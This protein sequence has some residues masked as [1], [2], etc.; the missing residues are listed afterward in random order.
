MLHQHTGW[1]V[2]ISEWLLLAVSVFLITKEMIVIAMLV[3]L[4]GRLFY[5]KHALKVAKA[6]AEQSPGLC[7]AGHVGTGLIDDHDPCSAV[8]RATLCPLQLFI[9]GVWDHSQRLLDTLVHVHEAGEK[10]FGGWRKENLSQ[11]WGPAGYQ[12]HHNECKW[13]RLRGVPR[14]SAGAG[15]LVGRGHEE[16]LKLE[17]VE[18]NYADAQSIPERAPRTSMCRSERTTPQQLHQQE[19][20]GEEQVAVGPG[21]RNSQVGRSQCT[22]PLGCAFGGGVK[23][24]G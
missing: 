24:G 20:G 9:L 21:G 19:W 15:F 22:I 13:H 18:S 1:L 6:V 10:V 5:F 3:L 2:C 14:F 11:A 23:S 17:G 12:D 7:K 16:I 4:H 8:G